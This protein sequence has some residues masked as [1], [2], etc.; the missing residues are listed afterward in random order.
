MACPGP[1]APVTTCLLGVEGVC[2]ELTDETPSEG[3]TLS[4]TGHSEELTVS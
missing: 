4:W 3:L 1:T 2:A